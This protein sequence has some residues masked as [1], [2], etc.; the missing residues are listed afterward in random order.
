[1]KAKYLYRYPTLK[2]VSFSGQ[3]I[4]L[5]IELQSVRI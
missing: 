5:T 4:S 3:F 2:I 1:M